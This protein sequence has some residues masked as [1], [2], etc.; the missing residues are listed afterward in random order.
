MQVNLAPGPSC[1]CDRQT[2]HN[3]MT[4]QK[5]QDQMILKSGNKELA[6]TGI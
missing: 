5:E 1:I 2:I 4:P 3:Q 6:V